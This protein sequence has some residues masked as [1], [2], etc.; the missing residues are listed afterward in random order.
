MTSPLLALFTRS[1]REDTRS[2]STYWARGGM[3]TFVLLI[4]LLVATISNSAG[5]LRI[6]APGL[7]FF[8]AVISLQVVCITLVGL[9][10]FASA[11]TEE[12]EEETL[13]L[14]RMT[15]LNPLSILL[16]K[17][18]SRLCGALL[19]LVALLPFTLLAITL[20]GVSLAQIL[21][22]YCTLGAYTFFLCNLALLWSVIAAH[23][24]RAALF[25]IASLT[26]F[27]T[28]GL[29]VGALQSG[30]IE[31]HWMTAGSGA[32]GKMEAVIAAAH[33]GTPIGRLTEI[34]ATG[35]SGAPAG[36]QVWT[37]LALGLAC[38][39]AAWAAFTHFADRA[40]DG[41]TAAT[42]RRR[43]LG[44]RFRRPP[45]PWKNALAWKDFHFLSGGTPGFLVRLV[46]YGGLAVWMIVIAIRK[47]EHVSISVL[48]L[49]SSLVSFAFVVELAVIASRVFRTEISAQTWSSLA[50]LPMSIRQLARGKLLGG[51]LA[52]VPSAVTMLLATGLNLTFL[53]GNTGMP[54]TTLVTSTVTG[55]VTTLFIVHLIAFLSLLIK[56]GALALGFVVAYAIAT[57]IQIISM[58]L[59]FAGGGFSGS[60]TN[61]EA[62]M[63]IGPIVSAFLYLVA[64]FFLYRA[65]LQRL[66]T[67]AAES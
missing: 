42:P 1:L 47:S 50:L 30:L 58:A 9:S 54:T 60:S 16:G 67:A 31:Y 38:F 34:L 45:R 33:A 56:R 41:A 10:F 65:I 3:A 46:G 6:G 39:F 40:A 23:T 28:G 4:L 11:I 2:K 61:L 29:L 49:S 14:L 44:I 18:T 32:D 13:G 15:N 37:N 19:L 35:F 64:I 20:G 36:W 55:W 21:A 17:S 59:I 51:L 24:A 66:E 48:P 7:Y 25:T 62:R 8:G 53:A 12:K 26:V 52:T 63:M 57:T 22:S 43:V 27:F 5:A